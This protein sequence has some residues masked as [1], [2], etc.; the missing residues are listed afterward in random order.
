MRGDRLALVGPSGCGK[1]TALDLLAGVLRPD[2]G[3]RFLFAP[4]AGEAALDMLEVWRRGGEAKLAAMRLHHLGY[5]LQVGGLL[6]FLSAGENILLPCRA[7][8]EL[9]ARRESVRELC[10]RLHIERLLGQ[11]PS[12]LSVGER[13]RVAIARAL[14]HDPSILLADEPTAA[15][16]PQHARLVLGLL[17]ELAGERGT[18]VI[19]VT[20]AP[21][22]A[23]EAGF[24]LVRVSTMREGDGGTLSRIRHSEEA[25]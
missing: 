21:E 1:S 4:R 16:D 11:M 24:R 22:M 20:H 23:E 8:G 9:A 6:P 25:A 14:A 7:L 17:A 5:V 19:M 15:L 10:E 2:G 13:Q 3:E 18:T 12:R